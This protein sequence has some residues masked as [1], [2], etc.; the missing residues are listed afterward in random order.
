MQQYLQPLRPY[1][2]LLTQ[3]QNKSPIAFFTKMQI[4]IT[5]SSSLKVCDFTIPDEIHEQI[6]E[7]VQGWSL[8]KFNPFIPH[9]LRFCTLHPIILLQDAQCILTVST[10]RRQKTFQQYQVEFCYVDR[11]S[12]QHNTKCIK[13]LAHKSLC[14]RGQTFRLCNQ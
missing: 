3:V 10:Q 12:K 4:V 11:L 9:H 8:H 5:V 1:R 6:H 2:F 7:Q 14:T 13:L